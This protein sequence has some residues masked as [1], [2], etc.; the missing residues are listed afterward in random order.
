MQIEKHKVVTLNYIL[1][2]D[3]GSIV[4]RSDD[5]SFVYLHGANNIIPGL[6]NA[7]AGKS[8]GDEF[9]VTVAPKDAYGLRDES[10]V[11]SVPR[12]MF[13]D[14]D[15]IEVGQT[16]IRQI[17]RELDE[18]GL[19]RDEGAARRHSAD[20][21]CP[22]DDRHPA[23]AARQGGRATTGSAPTRILNRQP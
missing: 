21:G 7:L 3:D 23:A 20:C 2:D 17:R 15:N 16:A 18:K 5:G 10:R 14:D 8:G 12:A 22:I 6:E 19:T 11:R 13:E 1:K 9:S 4:D